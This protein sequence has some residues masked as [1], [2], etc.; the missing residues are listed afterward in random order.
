MKKPRF[1][2]G[3]VGMELAAGVNTDGHLKP[4]DFRKPQT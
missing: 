3:A 1:Y 4:A 2:C